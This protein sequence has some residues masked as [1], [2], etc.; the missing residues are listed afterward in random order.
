MTVFIAEVNSTIMSSQIPSVA[1]G[2]TDILSEVIANGC[3]ALMEYV[4]DDDGKVTTRIV[5]RYNKQ[6]CKHLDMITL[7]GFALGQ[8]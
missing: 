6:Y 4:G 8:R 5:R 1:D 3:S 2:N 7:V